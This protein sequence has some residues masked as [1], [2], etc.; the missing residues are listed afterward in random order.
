[1]TLIIVSRWPWWWLNSLANESCKDGR[2]R[3]SQPRTLRGPNA[4][5]LGMTKPPANTE[6]FDR[7]KITY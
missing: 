5:P 4:V 6:G 3:S 1:M 7:K 2:L